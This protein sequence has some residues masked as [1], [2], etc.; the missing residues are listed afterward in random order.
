MTDI[1][2][3]LLDS[4][5]QQLQIDDEWAVRRERGFTERLSG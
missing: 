4:L 3:Q 5:Y 1:G 2:L